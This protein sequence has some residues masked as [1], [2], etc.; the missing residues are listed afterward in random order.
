[1]RVD[2]KLGMA[3]VIQGQFKGDSSGILAGSCWGS[4]TPVGRGVQLSGYPRGVLAGI[5]EVCLGRE[6]LAQSWR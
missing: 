3:T 6:D 1:M 5:A 2:P 4:G